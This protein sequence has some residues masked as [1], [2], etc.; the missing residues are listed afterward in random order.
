[1][2]FSVRNIS[3]TARDAIGLLAMEGG[4]AMLANA[5]A[6]ASI[7]LTRVERAYN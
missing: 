2:G 5:T 1:M 6:A 3:H 4:A 7:S